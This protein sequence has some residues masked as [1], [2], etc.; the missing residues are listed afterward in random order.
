METQKTNTFSYWLKN[1]IT[2]KMIMIG[3]LVLLMLIPLQFITDLIS[4]RA[5]RQ[6]RVVDAI[7][8]KWGKDIMIYGP[9]LKVPLAIESNSSNP[10]NWQ[11]VLYV[12]PSILTIDANVDSQLRK[13]GIY[14]TI[15]YHSKMNLTGS[16]EITH[17]SIPKNYTPL[18][19]KAQMVMR[20]NNLKGVTKQI[21]VTANGKTFNLANGTANNQRGHQTYFDLETDGI[22]TLIS[23]KDSNL[24]FAMNLAMNGSEQIQFIPIGKSTQVSLK[25]NWKT[26]NF[27]GAFIPQNENKV[28]QHGISAQWNVLDINRP[29]MQLHKTSL[30]D[31]NDYAFGVNFMVPVDEYLKTERSIK[32]GILV[33]ALTFLI[34]F[35]IQIM[36]K[37]SIH[38]FQYLMIGIALT[39][40]YTLLLSISE[41]SNFSNAYGIAGTSV[42]VL[43][44]LYS[45]SLLKSW[46]L[47]IFIAASL[48]SL[49][50][51][52]FI[53][54]QLESLS[55]LVG[56][57]GLF[58]I[59]AA[60][61]YLSRKIQFT[62]N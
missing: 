2:A 45:K 16:F 61:M 34:F 19:D 28:D 39:M 24:D 50:S 54:I 42:I 35:L 59:L 21:H 62:N 51:F 18:W 43:I 52:I 8:G 20:V 33:I 14:K 31:L 36:S 27:F 58:I 22:S 3:M 48:L 41:Q 6:S 49:Y 46:K 23:P 40:F 1:T 32:Y 30:P 7:N 9:V 60:V 25:S 12:F 17:L 11:E 47:P 37:I 4:E 56:S 57:I 13:Y 26:A 38:P 5:T 53:I 15:V 10:N 55:L 29:F 44:S